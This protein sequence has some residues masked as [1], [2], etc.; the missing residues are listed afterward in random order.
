MAAAQAL[1]A[2]RR[3]AEVAP[4]HLLVALLRQEEGI[5][6]PVLQKLNVDAAP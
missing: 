2:E 6:A 1:A 3:N 5:A 4:A